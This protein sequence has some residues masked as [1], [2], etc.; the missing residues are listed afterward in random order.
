MN[1]RKENDHQK[2]SPY[3]SWLVI[4]G[5]NREVKMM[6]WEGRLWDD[7]I[8]LGGGNGEGFWRRAHHGRSSSLILHPR[9]HVRD[10]GIVIVWYDCVVR[11]QLRVLYKVIMIWVWGGWI[12][13]PIIKMKESNEHYGS[14]LPLFWLVQARMIIRIMIMMMVF[15]VPW[16]SELGGLHD[17][18]W[19]SIFRGAINELESVKKVM[20]EI[21]RPPWDI[22]GSQLMWSIQKT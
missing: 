9:P 3:W 1:E 6:A 4:I 20:N 18:R 5:H 14:N 12:S 7:I 8:V 10:R 22:N 13:Y 17:D 21:V 16:R 2:L 19:M 15:H 11:C